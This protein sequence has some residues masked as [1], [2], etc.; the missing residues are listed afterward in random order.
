MTLVGV[1]VNS[2][3]DQGPC[4]EQ[5][6]KNIEQL[7]KECNKF[8]EHQ[9]RECMIQT[10]EKQLL[11]RTNAV[12]ELRNQILEANQFLMEAVSSDSE[13]DNNKSIR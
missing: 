9:A 7:L 11:D 10:L 4:R 3:M 8:R 1:L 6:M 12:R 2:P 5:L 13:V